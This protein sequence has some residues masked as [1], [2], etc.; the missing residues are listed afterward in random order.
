MIIL[1][2]NSEKT[3]RGGEQQMAY[4]T[5]TCK[6]QGIKSILGFPNSNEKL[7]EF[8]GKHEFESLHLPFGGTQLLASLKLLFWLK[9]NKVALIHTH[10]AKAHTVAVWA[11]ILGARTPVIVSKRTDFKVKSPYKFHHKCVK[12]ILCVSK[13]IE[14]ITREGMHP[15]KKD[16]VR[17]VHSGI[18]LDRFECAQQ[19]SL[20]KD[21]D[22]PEDKIL[23][24]NCSAIADHKDYQ[25]F[26]DTAQILNETHPDKFH[27]IIIGKGP[28]EKKIK[29]YV[30]LKHLQNRITFT[31]FI[32][33]LQC[34]LKSLDIFLMT[35]KEEGLG[36]SL[37]DAMVCEI[38]IVSTNAGGI[39]EIVIHE[40][41]GLLAKI[42]D[43]NALSDNIL[44]LIND[45]SLKAKV[46]KNAKEQ[47]LKSY[48][49]EHTAE[50]TIAVYKEVLSQLKTS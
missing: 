38:P 15:K 20:K 37:L 31:G 13:M 29:D 27:F 3:W 47:V 18:N 2:L 7:N 32:A 43:P 24:G 39:P 49:K 36:T 35:S 41:T 4:L 11:N 50:K 14:K 9:K 44:R 34:Y 19:L 12:A 33:N 28:D 21:F 26:V 23:I 30:D 10:T 48:S 8:C 6:E 46:I 17:T 45:D 5:E 1:H 25:T 22:I 40:Q 16:L 42:K